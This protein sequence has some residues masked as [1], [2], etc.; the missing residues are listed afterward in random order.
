MHH[1]SYGI[2]STCEICFTIL[3][4]QIY[5]EGRLTEISTLYNVAFYQH[6]FHIFLSHFWHL[7]F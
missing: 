2:D 6:V 3:C 1:Y 7:L 4:V 5:I